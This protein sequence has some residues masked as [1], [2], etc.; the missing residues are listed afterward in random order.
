VDRQ[1]KKISYFVIITYGITLLF[2]I[3]LQINGGNRNPICRNLIGISMI[4][5]L[6]SVVIVQKLIFREKLKP[7][8]DIT[9]KLDIWILYSILIP[10][11]MSLIINLISSALFNA[12]LFSFRE[13]Y[14][15]III[16]LTI[17]ALS[18]LVEELAWRG[19]LFNELKASGILKTSIIIGVIWALWHTPVCIWY[20]YPGSPLSGAVINFIQM[21]FISLII[22]YIRSKS[23]SVIQCALIHGM[24]N[25]MILTG[26]MDDFKIV[27]IKISLC[28]L[29][30]TLLIIIQIEHKRRR[31]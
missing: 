19:F 23:G 3:I 6:V 31:N 2:F 28:I 11:I 12:V 26:S 21:F 25:T 14:M 27:L 24:F 22:T 30:L 10:I 9:F 16:G 13:F 5:P 4:I 1:I 29:A 18:A 20:K 7:A 17:A 15:N 8:L